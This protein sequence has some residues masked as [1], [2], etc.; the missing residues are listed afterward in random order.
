MVPYCDGMSQDNRAGQCDCRLHPPGG[1]VVPVAEPQASSYSWGAA[2]V[3]SDF[4]VL[5]QFPADC[6]S[7]ILQRHKRISA[8]TFKVFNH[9]FFFLLKPLD[10]CQASLSFLCEFSVTSTY[11]RFTC[12]SF[13]LFPKGEEDDWNFRNKTKNNMGKG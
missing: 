13:S 2:R 3:G 10:F 11:P 7:K 5:P 4:L 12:C 8:E 6:D 9:S 1:H